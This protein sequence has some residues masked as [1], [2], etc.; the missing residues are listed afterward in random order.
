MP[1]CFTPKTFL[2]DHKIEFLVRL[3]EFAKAFWSKGNDIA[4][5]IKTLP[6]AFGVTQLV[7]KDLDG[8]GITS[9][10]SDNYEYERPDNATFGKS[11]HSSTLNLTT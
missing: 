10:N 3:L 1:I 9:A 11:L 4:F 2:R 6:H 7:M 8:N 5:G